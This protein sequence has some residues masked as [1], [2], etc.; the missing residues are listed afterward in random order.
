MY[1]KISPEPSR[2]RTVRR[3]HSSPLAT[4][5]NKPASTVLLCVGWVKSRGIGA[6]FC[7]AEGSTGKPPIGNS[8][9]SVLDVLESNISSSGSCI[10]G[11]NG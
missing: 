4:A 10:D 2:D 9:V 8:P 7:F 6:R 11:T 1:S 5:L 3:V